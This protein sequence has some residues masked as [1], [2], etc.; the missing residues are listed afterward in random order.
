[1]AIKE[2]LQSLNNEELARIKDICANCNVEVENICLFFDKKNDNCIFW[3][4]DK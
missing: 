1:M 2:W 4:A 3:R